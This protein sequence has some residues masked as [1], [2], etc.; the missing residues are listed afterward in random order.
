MVVVRGYDVVRLAADCTLQEL[1]I[2]WV[3][4]APNGCCRLDE[5]PL[6]LEEDHQC[7]RLDEAQAELLKDVGP[8][9]YIFDFL[10]H[11][12]G[13]EEGETAGPPGV[14]D[15]GGEALRL[16]NGAPQEDLGVK[17]DAKLW[18]IAG[19]RRSLRQPRPPTDRGDDS[20]RAP[21]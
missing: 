2:A 11:G 4:A 14:V 1:V 18:Q 8:A 12:M 13:E 10:E 5:E 9:Q 20:E 7:P 17:N 15:L 3:A 6:A 16:G 19:P 21:R